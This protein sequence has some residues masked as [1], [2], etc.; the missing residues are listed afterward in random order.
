MSFLYCGFI[1]YL[2][3]GYAAD[4]GDGNLYLMSYDF[5]RETV[6][7]GVQASLLGLSGFLVG[8]W[9]SQA[10]VP[11]KPPVVDPWQLRTKSMNRKRVVFALGT[12]SV[13]GFALAG[14]D[15]QIPLLQATLQVARNAGVA[16]VCLGAAAAVLVDGRTRFGR[17]IALGALIPLAYLIGFGFLSYGFIV[18][19]CFV[20]FWLAVLRRRRLRLLPLMASSL[21]ITYL[22]LSLFLTWMDARDRLRAVLWGQAG[23]SDRLAAIWIAVTQVGPLNFTNF[24]DLDLLNLRLNQ[25]I[26][27]GKVIEYHAL[28]PDLRLHGES[29]YSALFA[30]VPRFLWP[31]KPEMGGSE[32]LA[33]HSGLHFSS[34]ASFGAG[35][36][37]EFFVNFGWPGIFLGF[38]GLGVMVA[39]LDRKAARALYSGDLVDF[40]RWFTVGLAFIA[41]LTSM[42]FMVNTAIITFAILT[43]ARRGLAG[44]S[45][46]MPS[47]LVA[48]GN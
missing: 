36:V 47:P 37:I 9:L 21:A 44:G 43:I 25:Y 6:L 19:T 31:G 2:V 34:S 33:E 10:R 42:F 11:A 5:D 13:V 7:L 28:R 26:F 40:A 1:S 29:L 45:A 22:L 14:V 15:T 39:C 30:W 32:F 24:A 20:G 46:R 48:K 3:P 8:V 27:V 35:P 4:R 38:I 12:F 17:W 18:F 41:P 23:L 16:V